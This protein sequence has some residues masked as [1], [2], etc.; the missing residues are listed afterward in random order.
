VRGALFG[1]VDFSVVVVFG[2]GGGWGGGGGESEMDR[3]C[4]RVGNHQRVSSLSLGVE[5]YILMVAGGHTGYRR[6]SKW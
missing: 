6:H 1:L 2:G 5:L 4:G 3:A